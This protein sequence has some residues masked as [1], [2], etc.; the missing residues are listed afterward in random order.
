[1]ITRKYIFAQGSPI[2]IYDVVMLSLTF[3]IEGLIGLV[4]VVKKEALQIFRLKGK[5]AVVL[6]ILILSWSWLIVAYIILLFLGLVNI[7]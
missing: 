6:G 3:L 5:K 1:M 4:F 2:N 7:G